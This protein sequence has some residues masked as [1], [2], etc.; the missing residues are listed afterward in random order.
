MQ[1]KTTPELSTEIKNLQDELMRLRFRKVTDDVENVSIFKSLKRNIAQLKTIIKQKQIS[2]LAPQKEMVNEKGKK[3]APKTA[4][5]KKEPTT[6]TPIPKTSLSASALKQFKGLLLG[7]KSTLR[8]DMNQMG[9]EALGK[10]RAEASGDLSNVPLH[11]ADLGT[12]TY[13]QDFTIGMME[14]EGIELKQIDDALERIT[15]KT[16]GI[17]EECRKPIPETRLRVIPYARQCIKCQSKT[18][19][20]SR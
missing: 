8:I 17:C 18:E 16:F 7:L 12:D 20:T 3:K 5:A 4:S 1:S 13:E 9:D 2:D 11:S 6:A 10:S 15:D 14:T 19:T